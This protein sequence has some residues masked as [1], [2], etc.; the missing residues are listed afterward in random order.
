MAKL[1]QETTL[2]WTDILP[3]VL[4]QVCCAP[5][6]RVSFFPFEILYGRIRPKGDLGEIEK[7]QTQKQLQGLGKT[8]FEVHRWVI[9]RLPISLATAVYPYKPGDQVWVKDWK[10]EPLKPTW[11]G[12]YPDILN[13]LRLQG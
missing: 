11:K 13:I 8:V 9:D 5:M 2:P 12:P 6:A 7:L 1:C 10:K 3:L 4:L